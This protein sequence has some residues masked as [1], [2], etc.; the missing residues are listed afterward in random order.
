MKRRRVLPEWQRNVEFD[1]QAAEQFLDVGDASADAQADLRAKFA[2]VKYVL[3]GGPEFAAEAMAKLLGDNLKWPAEP[4]GSRKSYPL[5]K[6]GPCLVASHD[7]GVDS[8]LAL[9]HEL[10]KALHEAGCTEVTFIYFGACIG[11]DVAPETVVVASEAVDGLHD[12]ERETP[13]SAE[14]KAFGAHFDAGLAT[15]LAAAATRVS[16]PSVIGKAATTDD[17]VEEERADWLR[18]LHEAGLLAM[19]GAESAALAVFCNRTGNR[20]AFVAT[21]PVDEPGGGVAPHARNAQRVVLEWIREQAVKTSG[22]ASNQVANCDQFIDAEEVPVIDMRPWYEGSSNGRQE[23]VEAMRFACEKVGFFF[24]RNHGVQPS[25]IADTMDVSKRY[26]DQPYQVKAQIAMHSGYPYGYEA[27][28]VLVRSEAGGAGATTADLKE[29]FNLCIGPEGCAHP[30]MPKCQWPDTPADMRGK[31]TAH[32]RACEKVVNELLKIAALA[33]ELP[34]DFFADK[35]RRHVAALR[36]LNYPDTRQNPPKPGQ[37]RASPHTDYGTLTLLTA[38]ANPDGLQVMKKDD[39]WLDVKI[40]GD[41]L[42]VNVGD[43]LSRWTNDRWRSTRH[44][45]VVKEGDSGN[46]RQSV[47][48]FHNP[49][50]DALVRTL[51]SCVTPSSPDKYDDVQ[52]GDYL[53]MKHFS[54]MGYAWE[55]DP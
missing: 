31:C 12:G 8:M 1:E 40:P 5:Y 46:R 2:E 3:M 33:L 39:T 29:T 20:G 7:D 36:I 13:G 38:G 6:A 50:P 17:S 11:I 53:M 51:A 21:V 26:F 43:M 30:T 24:I 55:K 48:F 25:L 52:A 47:A 41:C 19:S 35:V 27:S 15:E 9:L 22:K 28:E 49:S 42:T 10:T 14:R 34:E 16:L 4:V 18:R 37:L 32:Y 44:R 54:A 23:V 45:V